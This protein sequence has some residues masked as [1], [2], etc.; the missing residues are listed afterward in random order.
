VEE[1]DICLVAGVTMVTRETIDKIKGLGKKLVVRLDNVPRNSR[2]RNTGTSRLKE[3]SQKANAIV[4]QSEWAKWYLQDFI[5][6][7]GLIIYN[8]VDTEVFGPD[9][10]KYDFKG[11]PVFLYS[12][13]NRDET[14][15]WEVAWYE[16]QLIQRA[17]REAKLVL[18][19]NFSPEQMEYNFD[20]FRGER[21]EY[22]GIVD[23]QK[24]MAKIMRS[25]DYF[26]ATYFNDCFSNTYLEA[27]CSGVKLTRIS[28]TGGTSEMLGLWETRGREFFSLKRM[29]EDYL[30]L[31]GIL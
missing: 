17:N 2:N 18:V 21:F 30:N 5:A 9:G 26:L 31:F 4:W 14:K 24:E 28:K 29:V 15:N 11:K 25:C 23:N 20:F 3:F 7:P 6:K 13:F 1:A 8:G 16:Y 22:L 27:L 10:D 12:R 19:G